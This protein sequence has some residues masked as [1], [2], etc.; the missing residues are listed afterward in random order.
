MDG[1][2]LML[3]AVSLKA[4]NLSPLPS[5]YIEPFDA[6]L[7]GAGALKNKHFLVQRG[8]PTLLLKVRLKGTGYLVSC[9]FRVEKQSWSLHG[10]HFSL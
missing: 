10:V 2:K 6:N 1:K 8:S 7:P 3:Q 5:S 4:V 9:L